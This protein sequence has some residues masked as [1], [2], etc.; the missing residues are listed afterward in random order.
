[1]LIAADIIT[2]YYYLWLL[3]YQRPFAVL[4][5]FSVSN[6]LLLLLIII[7]SVDLVAAESAR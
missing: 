1:M 4:Q 3:A 2:V 6:L 5:A 7:D